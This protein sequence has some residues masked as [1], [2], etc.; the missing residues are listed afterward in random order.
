MNGLLKLIR[1]I[2]DL[3]MITRPVVLIPVWGF[4]AL[5]FRAAVADGSSAAF[6]T[7]WNVASYHDY[8][9]MLIFSLSVAA[10]YIVNQIADVEADKKNGGLPLIAAGIVSIRAAYVTMFSCALLSIVLP[11]LYHQPLYSWAAVATLGIGILYSVKPFRLS[12]R[13]V[14]D[15][16]SNA[17]GYGAIA[18]AVGWIAAG[19]LPFTAEFALAALPYVFLMG[20]G[21]IS[22][23]IP[24]IPGDK[25]DSKRT[26]AVVFGITRSHC[27]AMFF[28]VAAAGFGVVSNDYISVACAL[29]S[30]PVYVLFLLK[31]SAIFMEATYKVGGAICMIA[32]FGA[33]PVFIP[34]SLFVVVFTM[35]YFRIR[36][37]VLYPS[38][39][40]I[41]SDKGVS[42]T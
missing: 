6:S 1:H 18:F 11:I 13:P 20:A 4:S 15:F 25:D 28:L 9:M 30:L 35:L 19:K 26:T 42:G 12:G 23:T 40:P 17:V 27:I 31:R 14:V 7:C 21:S 16:V 36:H 32:A 41:P 3:C 37:G 33:L 39:V 5:G 24:D 2:T 8:V 38:L 22:S 29:L 34:V 10:V